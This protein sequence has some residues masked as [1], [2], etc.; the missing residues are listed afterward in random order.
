MTH[1]ITRRITLFA[2]VGALLA[3]AALTSV[4]SADAAA[5]PKAKSATYGVCGAGDF[6]LYY[7]YNRAGGLYHFG[8]SDSNLNNDHFE[9]ASVPSAWVGNNTMSAWNRGVSDS[10]GLIDVLVYTGANRTGAAACVR[11]GASGNLRETFRN[12][13]ESYK[14]TTRSVCNNYRTPFV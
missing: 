1:V 12:Q 6:C 7:L 8:G 3:A 2:L 9:R 4:S 13:I 5:K 11:Q 14:W 10:S